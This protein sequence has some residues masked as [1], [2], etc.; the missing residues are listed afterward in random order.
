MYKILIVQQEQ[1]IID[2]IKKVIIEHFHEVQVFYVNSGTEALKSIYEKQPDIV[3][4][5]I[6]MLDMSG[7]DVANEV[8]DMGVKTRIIFISKYDYFEFARKALQ[9]DV[10]DYL[11]EPVSEHDILEVTNRIMTKLEKEKDEKQEEDARYNKIEKMLNMSSMSFVYNT[12]LGSKTDVKKEEY[13]E[14]LDLSER[15]YWIV[16]SFEKKAFEPEINYKKVKE[17]LK[18]GLDG[19]CD[20]IIGP[21]IFDRVYVYISINDLYIKNGEKAYAVNINKIVLDVLDENIDREVFVGIGSIQNLDKNSLSYEEAMLSLSNI[22]LE[23]KIE[24]SNEEMLDDDVESKF[25]YKECIK[26]ERK[27]IEKIELGKDNILDEFNKILIMCKNL[28]YNEKCNIIIEVLVA[29][30]QTVNRYDYDKKEKFD[31]TRLFG[32]IMSAKEDINMKAVE[33]MQMIIS[34]IRMKQDDKISDTVKTA[35]NYIHENYNQNISLNDISSMVGVSLQYFSKIFKDETGYKFVEW[36]NKLRI[37]KA[38]ELMGTTQLTVKEVCFKV[39]YNDPNYF[40]R[41][42]KK[43]ENVAPTEYI[44]TLNNSRN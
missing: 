29:A 4:M 37:N 38:K 2:S 26:V 18:G 33:W 13:K 24:I 35:M 5:T 30:C 44:A 32:E 23:G 17:V 9:I 43:Y 22:R 39:G 12:V 28:E 14:I 1:S 16:I 7:I 25:N 8:K 6:E 3:F 11:L 27:I 41:I 21:E 20:Y 42:F 10:E 15:G 19:N 36:V 31:Y 40:S 34:I